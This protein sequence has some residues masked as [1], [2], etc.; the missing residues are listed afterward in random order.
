MNSNCRR[1]TERQLK[2]ISTIIEARSVTEGC[3]Q[4]GIARTTFY[5]WLTDDCFKKEYERQR[6]IVVDNGL[7]LL[8]L[9]ADKAAQTLIDLL[10]ASSESVRLRTAQAIWDNINKSIEIDDIQTRLDAL[11]ERLK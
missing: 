7:D 1:L 3:K 10:D 6:K 5:D 11:E 8:K 4:C 9:S 2:A